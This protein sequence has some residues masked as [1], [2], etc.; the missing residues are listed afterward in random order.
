MLTHARSLYEAVMSNLKDIL[1]IR[2][3]ILSEGLLAYYGANIPHRFYDLK[4]PRSIFT[5]H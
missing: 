4:K 3:P 2:I 5:S 1:S